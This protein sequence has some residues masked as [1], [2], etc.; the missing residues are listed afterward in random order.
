VSTPANG[1]PDAASVEEGANRQTQIGTVTSVAGKQS[2][3]VRV[4]RR[5]RHPRYHKFISRRSKFMAHDE[6]NECAVGD[7]VE[8]VASRPLSARKRWRVRTIVEK[9]VRQGGEAEA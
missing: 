4:D 3:V 8:I 2:I 1:T 5:V 7:V 6:R 9:A